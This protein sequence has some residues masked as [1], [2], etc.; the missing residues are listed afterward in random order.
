MRNREDF[1]WTDTIAS[2]LGQELKNGIARHCSRARKN[3]ASVGRS[4]HIRHVD[5]GVLLTREGLAKSGMVVAWAAL[6]GHPLHPARVR[7]KSWLCDRG[8]PVP[9][10]GHRH[11]CRVIQ[12]DI[13]H[14]RR[15][16]PYAKPHEIWAPAVVAPNYPIHAW[17]R[18][19]RRAYLEIQKLSAF[20]DVMATDVHQV[21]MMGDTGTESFS[22]VFLTGGAVVSQPQLSNTARFRIE[23]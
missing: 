12:R 22:G 17:H 11:E 3:C 1:V 23:K 14:P 2:E 18:Y 16:Y 20:S 9:H 21:L 19:M 15:P 8:S 7:K 13:Q 4:L 5:A 10:A 6:A